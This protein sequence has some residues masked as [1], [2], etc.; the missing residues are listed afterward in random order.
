MIV[1][2]VSVEMAHLILERNV[3]M[4]QI[5]EILVL[6][7]MEDNVPIVHQIVKKLLYMEII[8]G[9]DK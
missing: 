2:V 6:H 4:G 7:L 5:M 9:M 3:M 1:F 8:A